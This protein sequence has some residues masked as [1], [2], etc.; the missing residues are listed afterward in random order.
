MDNRYASPQ[1]FALMLTNY[2]VKG[3]GTCKANKIG[4]GSDS[5]QLIKS[6]DRG[7][8]SSKLDPRLGMIIIR[9]TDSKI[10]QTVGTVQNWKPSK[11]TME[12]T[13]AETELHHSSK[14]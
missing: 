8:F 1:L 10:L 12:T 2:N 14:N 6:C 11:G 3:I 7:A 9:W 4:F 5:I 13:I